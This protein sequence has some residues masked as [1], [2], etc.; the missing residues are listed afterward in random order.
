MTSKNDYFTQILLDWNRNSN[1]RVMPWKGEK[2]P[3]LIWLSEIILQQTR[4]AQG[5]EYFLKFKKLFPTID[6][7]ANAHENDVLKAWEG[8]GYYS[9]ARN[10]HF[11][12]K[13]VVSDFCGKFPENK[14][15]LL[16]LKG[17]GEYTAAAIASFAYNLPHAVVD[18][19]VIRVLSRVFGI[20][21]AFDT[22]DGKK[23]F[24]RL[25]QELLCK[26]NPA[27]F[28]QS[29]MDFG[30]VIC[31]PLQPSCGICPMQE[32]CHAFNNNQQKNFPVKS[33]KIEKRERFFYFLDL[34]FD[35]ETFIEQ[36]EGNDIWRNL[37]QF[38]LFE[39]NKALVEIPRD[40][41]ADKIGHSEFEIEFLSE[42]YF[43]MLTHQKINAWFISIKIENPPRFNYL[44]LKRENLVKFAFPKIINLYFG[45]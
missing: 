6:D 42:R 17:V 13:Q 38:P 26:E 18:G 22:S 41:V 30:A 21:V 8:L 34:F 4:V 11:A 33:K 31:T 16:K 36:R 27:A 9:R 35:D 32:I 39:S 43:Q 19:N 12:A 15:D 29:I 14:T 10:L 24:A 23:I 37:Y 3:Y 1:T 7:L 40:L 5:W 25:A 45:N 44:K 20:D 2:N 28:N